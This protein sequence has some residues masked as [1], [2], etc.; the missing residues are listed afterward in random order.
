MTERRRLIFRAKI[1]NDIARF[2]RLSIFLSSQQHEHYTQRRVIVSMA[3]MRW[4]SCQS[5]AE[6][7]QVKRRGRESS[8]ERTVLS[9]FLLITAWIFDRSTEEGNLSAFS[10]PFVGEASK[11]RHTGAASWEFYERHNELDIVIYRCSMARFPARRECKPVARNIP[12]RVRPSDESSRGRLFPA[13][14]CILS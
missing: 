7:G 3:T 1:A 2:F 10:R 11:D 12:I 8:I 9:G 14:L 6:G 5:Y 4:L 13:F